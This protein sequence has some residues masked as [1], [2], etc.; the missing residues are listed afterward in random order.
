MDAEVGKISRR[1]P[2][3]TPGPSRNEDHG[4]VRYR[5]L[6][7]IYMDRTRTQHAKDEHVYLIVDVLPNAPTR[8]E[9][10]QVGVEVFTPLESPDHPRLPASRSGDLNEV[11]RIFLHTAPIQ[12]RVRSLPP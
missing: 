9:T 10:H 11:H 3:G 6:A 1:G 8:L 12:N 2:R 4:P 7:A 5:I